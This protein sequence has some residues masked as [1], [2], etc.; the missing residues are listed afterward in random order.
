M[1]FLCL[2][3]ATCCRSDE[4]TEDE[5]VPSTKNQHVQDEPSSSSFTGT[6]CNKTSVSKRRCH[7]IGFNDPPVDYLC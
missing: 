2:G 6:R 7:L 5:E 3:R 4:K 1:D